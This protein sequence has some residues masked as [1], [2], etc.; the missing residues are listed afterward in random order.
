MRPVAFSFLLAAFV[1]SA[2]PV[3]PADLS[4]INRTIAK[5][6]VYQGKPKYCLLVF[7]V[8]AKFR[9][10]LVVDGKTAYLDR[11]GN[12]DLTEPGNQIPW[13]NGSFL[14]KELTVADKTVQYTNLSISKAGLKNKEAWRIDVDSKN[15][16]FRAHR[17]AEGPLLFA[18]R[19]QDAP[20][21]HFDGPLSMGL[22]NYCNARPQA[23]VRGGKP[24]YM[25]AS[26][27]TPGLGKGTFAYL[28]PPKSAKALKPL[29]ELEFAH[30]DPKE[31]AMVVRVPMEIVDADCVSYEGLVPVPEAAV[32]DKAK[33][34]LKFADWKEGAVSAGTFQVAIIDPKPVGKS[35]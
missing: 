34:T 21:I 9:A 17:D 35:K 14:A 10:W 5:E 16:Q 12:G 18:D 20:V 26:I 32:G 6:P 1:V 24:A 11:K 8:E 15:G 29:A 4:Q 27:G 30:R 19:P 2:G 7:G 33:V 3:S 31:K 22:H 23:L 13:A 28:V 25:I